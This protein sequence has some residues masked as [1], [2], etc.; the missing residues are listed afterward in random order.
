VSQE[1]CVSVYVHVCE[2]MSTCAYEYTVF[3]W[4][5]L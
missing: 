5:V 1:V 2:Y 3:C 4:H